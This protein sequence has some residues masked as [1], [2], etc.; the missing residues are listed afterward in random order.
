MSETRANQDGDRRVRRTRQ[1]LR[2]ALIA[3]IQ[4]RGYDATS[5]QD[6]VER[7]DVGRSTFYGHFTDKE[8]LLLWAFRELHMSGAEP[9]S[10]DASLVSVSRSM[11]ERAGT[12]R[13]LFRAV[14]GRFGSGAVQRRMEGEVFAWAGEEFRRLA[15][16]SDPDDVAMSAAIAVGAFMSLLRWWIEAEAPVPSN[17]VSR[18]FEASVV[19]GICEALRIAPEALTGESAA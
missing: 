10:A 14:F 13:G 2:D 9:G 3:L 19:P 1:A 8:D 15:P 18:A 11:L 6:V 5:V 12:E 4:E 7:A 16:A 17:R